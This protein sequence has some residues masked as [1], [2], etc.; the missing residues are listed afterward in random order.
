MIKQETT[1]KKID[2]IKLWKIITISS[3]V[4]FLSILSFTINFI[5]ITS[6]VSK[7]FS[8][9]IF[10]EESQ[11]QIT[12]IKK[13]QKLIPKEI[14]NQKLCKDCAKRII[15]G[16]IVKKG[17]ENLPQIAVMIDN[18]PGARP[19]HGINNAN[20]VYEAE[21]EGSF[22]RYMAIFDSNDEIDEIGA[23]RSARPYF[24]S[25]AEELN[26]IY[27]HC[28]GSPEALVK[29][30]KDGV[31]D[32]NEFYNG[33]YFWRG[34]Q[35]KAPHNIIVS[36]ANIKK[37][38][39]NKKIKNPSFLSWKYKEEK[40][41]TTKG[42]YEILNPEIKINFSNDYFKISWKYNKEENNYTRLR[43][44]KPELTVEKNKITAK[45]IIIQKI[46]ASVLDKKLRLKMKTIGTGE[47][48]ICLDGECKEG[49]WE[50]RALKSR[51]R[52]YYS[53]KKEVEFNPG[54]TWIEVIRPEIDI[55]Y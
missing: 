18:H 29:I 52:F 39:F 16:K 30:I 53:N 13:E 46:P 25:W 8:S 49:N 41:P 11:K 43:Y 37:Y 47:A 10:H 26:A 35:K 12:I 1:K 27:T 15:D 22:T 23:V 54:K 3:I 38:I 34:K 17:K 40:T 42:E 33:T 9:I 44:N 20:L 21:V 14:P 36:M 19:V 45:N 51:T 2:K 4:L 32:F 31:I 5:F 50:K 6:G 24:I 48:I 28:G 55:A 7:H